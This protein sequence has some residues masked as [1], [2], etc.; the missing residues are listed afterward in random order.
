MEQIPS[1][2]ASLMLHAVLL[3]MLGLYLYSQR[4]EDPTDDTG[5]FAAQLTDS[6]DSLVDSDHAG[7]PFTTL[8]T[9]EAP[10]MS[11]VPAP[12]DTKVTNQPEIP[13]LDKFAPDIVDIEKPSEAK[14]STKKSA[15]K[16]KKLDF[17]PTRVGFGA[18]I[19]NGFIED[20]TAPF[21]GRQSAAIKA[22]LLR[23]EGGTVR[24]E[25]AVDG[26]L[27]WIVRHQKSDGGWSLDTS[28]QCSGIACPEPTMMVSDT[29]ATG[30]ALLPLMGAGHIPNGKSRYAQNVN[31]GI[32]W[33]LDHQ[34]TETGDLFT[35]GN[36]LSWLYSHAIAT[37]ALCEAYG[38]TGDSNLQGPAQGAI[39]FIIDSQDSVGG[40]WRYTP[41]MA[42]DTSVF[43][44]Q[45][46]ALRSAQL[47]GLK[48]PAATMKGCRTF[49]DE[50]AI[51]GKKVTYSYLVGRD[52]S[53]VM[54]AE[55]LL[56]RQYLGW[57]REHPSLSKGAGQVARD[58]LSND[59]RNI[60][61][62]Y[63]GTQ[64]L[65]NMNTGSLNPDDKPKDPEKAKEKEQLSDAQK[66]H[67]ENWRLWNI[68]VRDGLVRMQMQGNGCDR[69]SWDPYDPVPD[70]WG[71]RAG[72]LYL[73]ALSTL[74]LEVYYR[75]LPLY[76]TDDL[77]KLDPNALAKKSEEAGAK[78]KVG[79]DSKQPLLMGP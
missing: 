46:F 78:V 66:M 58:L 21:S 48:I 7:D 62:W 52:I 38:L 16:V 4:T 2:G 71:Q 12:E 67:N 28:S 9:D 47:A 42:G 56:A 77:D 1:W 74:T 43:G 50:V 65:H 13:A 35:D 11:L 6:L 44:W 63:Y 3:L 5:T 40:G 20:M 72:R 64:L 39:N 59:D 22:K 17:I 73:T 15:K 76:H 14:P 49:L 51:D 34:N 27:D 18:A 54:P 36:P 23:R 8:K 75:Y 37:M 26:G 53:P 60:Y 55:A 61:Y 32:K 19:K 68:R 33:L 57:P 45:M 69:G 10:S 41:G 25:K 79:D 70:R 30:L 31:R 24:S 29:G